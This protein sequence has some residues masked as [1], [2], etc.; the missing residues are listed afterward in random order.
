MQHPTLSTVEAYWEALREGRLVPRRADV[1]PRGIDRALENAFILE[2]IAPGMARFRLAGMHL[3]DLLGMEVR[4]MPLTSFFTPDAR[5]QVSDALEHVFEEPASARFQLI[6]ERSIGKPAMEAELILLPLKSDLGDV[7]RALGCLVSTGEIGRT[8]RRF[9]VA[10]VKVTPLLTQSDQA[11]PIEPEPSKTENSF[12]AQGFSEP[13]AQFR[14]HPPKAVET[15]D[16]TPPADQKD[17]PLKGERPYLRL[18][19]D[20]D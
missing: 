14:R 2:R 1:D 11:A 13:A 20:G 18:V 9:D 16:F 4:G 8:P 5:R 3:N 15:T 12:A 19:R 10:E 17:G 7:S 6:A